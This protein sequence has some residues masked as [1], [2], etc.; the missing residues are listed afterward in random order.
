MKSKLS[1]FLKHLLLMTCDLVVQL[2]LFS[3]DSGDCFVRLSEA[4]LMFFSMFNGALDY[5]IYDIALL[6]SRENGLNS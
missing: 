2:W 3:G 4:T 6:I 1:G 5:K